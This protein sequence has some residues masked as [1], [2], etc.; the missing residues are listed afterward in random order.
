MRSLLL[1]ATTVR[2]RVCLFC[3]YLFRRCVCVS[4]SSMCLCAIVCR[5]QVLTLFS[6][7]HV[8]ELLNDL[9]SMLPDLVDALQC[10]SLL[11]RSVYVFSF[12][13]FVIFFVVVV[14]VVNV[15]VV[16]CC[17]CCCC[18][19]HTASNPEVIGYALSALSVLTQ[20]ET[21]AANVAALGITRKVCDVIVSVAAVVVVV[22]S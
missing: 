3:L 20:N 14:V 12:T 18:F 16:V 8:A 13:L 11:V 21:R 6:V 22:H 1:C 9:S 17:C 5:S 4:V 2:V 15:V 7:T 19:N 10:M